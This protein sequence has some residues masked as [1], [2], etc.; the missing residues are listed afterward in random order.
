MS[1]ADFAIV[2]DRS[3]IFRRL[4]LALPHARGNE[5]DMGDALAG[6]VTAGVA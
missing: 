3:P 5:C 4:T 2:D 1:T 6:G